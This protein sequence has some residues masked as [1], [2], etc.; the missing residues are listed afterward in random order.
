[1][2]RSLIHTLFILLLFGLQFVVYRFGV[3]MYETPKLVAAQLMFL[4]LFILAA[5]YIFKYRPT[6][7]G[8]MYFIFTGILIFLLCL[9]LLLF[10]SPAIL[11][12]NIFRFQGTFLLILLLCFSFIASFFKPTRVYYFAGLATLVATTVL[13]LLLD[14]NI[15]GRAIALLG[16]PNM[17]AEAI[18]FIWPWAF[19]IP[20]SHPYR[21]V[22]LRVGV[23]IMALLLLWL[24][25]SRSGMLGFG[26]QSILLFAYFCVPKKFALSVPAVFGIILACSVVP[27]LERDRT[28]ENR[29]EIWLTAAVAGSASPIIGNG[30]G[31]V[32]TSLYRAA[33]KVENTLRYEYVDSSHNILLDWWVQGG[34]IGLGV[35]LVLICYSFYRFIQVKDVLMVVLLAGVLCTL[36]FNPASIVALVH[37]WWLI[38]RGFDRN[39]DSID[40]NGVNG[41]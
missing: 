32:E 11:W 31:S 33:V 27:L 23:V 40:R 7:P 19:L 6:F 10:N 17:L 12:G 29:G 37:L 39:M 4:G 24:S 26:V 1:M 9:H 35:F 13:T 36:F 5:I 25:G 16:E 30:F 28:W 21:K 22:A 38:G 34:L 41:I 15:S 8:R 2:I 18:I 20:I 3:S 14:A